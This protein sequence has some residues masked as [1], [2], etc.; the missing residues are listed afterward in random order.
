M[1]CPER[2]G[3]LPGGGG[4]WI[5]VLKVERGLAEHTRESYT[6]GLAR[7]PK[8]EANLLPLLFHQSGAAQAK[9]TGCCRLGWPQQ[10]HQNPNDGTAMA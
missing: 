8:G 10:E 1:I 9:R 2:Q 3:S 6:L 4:H 7:T 5:W